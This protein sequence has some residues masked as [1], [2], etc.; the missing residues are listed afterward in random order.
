MNEDTDD[1]VPPEELARRRAW[2]H[3]YTNRLDDRP[4]ELPLRCPCCGNKTLDE[5]GAFEICPVCFWEDDGQDDYDADV[6]R[7]GPNGSLSLTTARTNYRRFGASDERSLGH[8]RAP[9]PEE[10]P[11]TE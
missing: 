10:L 6:I 2:F 9:R 1:S 11:D 7:G 4:A 8:V 3:E 5:R